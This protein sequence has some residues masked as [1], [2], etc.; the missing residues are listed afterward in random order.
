MANIGHAAYKVMLDWSLK[1]STAATPA[2]M[3]VG[4]SLGVPTTVSYSEIGTG[5]GYARQAITFGAAATPGSSASA[6]NNIA[7]SFGT[8]ATSQ[9]ISGIFLSDS[10]SSGAGSMYWYGTINPTRTPLG[11]DTVSLAA[12]G[13]GITLS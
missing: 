10:I 13:L 7:A 3:V 5:S 9:A 6:S 12:G 8:F 11:G 1:T 4:L 2:S